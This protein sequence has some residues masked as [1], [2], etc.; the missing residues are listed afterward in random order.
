M[1]MKQKS[2]VIVIIFLPFHVRE[3]FSYHM[4]KY[5]YTKLY[6]Y[7]N[8]VVDIQKYRY[9]IHKFRYDKQK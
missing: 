4:H 3:D 2:F 5:R 1:K 7:T 6:I 9:D 8:V